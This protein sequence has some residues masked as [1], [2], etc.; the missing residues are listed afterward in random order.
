MCA[1]F[2]FIY[3]HCRHLAPYFHLGATHADVQ[4]ESRGCCAALKVHYIHFECYTLHCLARE[5]T[6]RWCGIVVVVAVNVLIL[7]W[8]VLESLVIFIKLKKNNN[9]LI[10]LSIY[11]AR[12]QMKKVHEATILILLIR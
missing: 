7:F 10:V 12:S 9:R 8:E 11:T 3:N 1:A 6:Q 2:I 4:E 5:F